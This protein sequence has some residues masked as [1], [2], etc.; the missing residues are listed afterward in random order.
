MANVTSLMLTVPSLGTTEPSFKMKK[1]MAWV[2]SSL[3]D[4]VVEDDEGVVPV[5]EPLEYWMTAPV[6]VMAYL[7]LLRSTVP[8]LGTTEPSFRMKKEMA[9]VSFGVVEPSLP[10]L[11][12]GACVV[13]GEESPP[14]YWMTAPLLVMAYLTLLRSTLPSFLT[15]APSLVM[16]KGMLLSLDVLPLSP[17]LSFLFPSLPL[18]L[19]P[20]VLLF[21]FP[22]LSVLDPWFV[23][24]P[25]LLPL[26]EYWMT[27]PLLVMAYLTL[28]RFTLPSFLTT[29]PFLV[30]KKEMLLSLDGLSLLPFLSFLFPS[31][32]LFLFPSLSLLD[33]WFVPWPLS[34]PLLEYWMTAPLLVMAYLTLLRSTLPSFLTTSPFL[35]MKKEMLLSVDVLPL[36]PLLLVRGVVDEEPWPVPG[37]VLGAGVVAEDP[38]DAVVL[39]VDDP[40]LWPEVSLLEVFFVCVS[41]LELVDLD[42]EDEEDFLVMV[43]PSLDASFLAEE[44]EAAVSVR[45]TWSASSSDSSWVLPSALVTVLVCWWAFFFSVEDPP[46]AAADEDFIS[47][48]AVFL[49]EEADEAEAASSFSSLSS[50]WSVSDTDFDELPC[51]DG[52]GVVVVVEDPEEV[53]PDP[54]LEE[55]LLEELLEEL[56]ELDELLLFL[57]F[58]PFLLLLSPLL[59]LP[60]LLLLLPPCLLSLPSPCLL[61]PSP[62]FL[63]L[64][65]PDCDDEDDWDELLEELLEEVPEPPELVLDTVLDVIRGR[66]SPLGSTIWSWLE[67]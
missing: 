1:E 4:G 6:L 15:T 21:L 13:V 29:S 2:S 50:V 28:L 9:W 67:R 18:F 38:P 66:V 3:S 31:V 54:D 23:P 62:F 20:S 7:T 19:F 64:P 45:L 30:M 49:S 34:F 43:L 63:P 51:L 61:S 24:W 41:L 53:E 65:D 59:L 17:F 8:S 48:V 11:V 14:E 52:L 44:N 16:K 47:P 25:L 36:P 10:D 32:L 5:E 40:E 26:L 27:A 58:P 37:V 60:P 33:P 46:A 42:A 35:L 57:S 12:V 39:V 56:F 22:S 55:E